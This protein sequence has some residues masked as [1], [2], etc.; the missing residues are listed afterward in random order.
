MITCKLAQILK[1]RKMTMYRVWKD[2]GITYPTLLKLTRN[3]SQMYDAQVLAKLCRALHCQPGDLLV[4][5]P[6]RFPR[7]PKRFPRLKG[8][9]PRKS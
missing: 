8:R 3:K 1:R 5:E 4:W 6:K 9:R 2:T 7:L